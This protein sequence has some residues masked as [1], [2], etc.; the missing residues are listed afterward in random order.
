MTLYFAIK[1]KLFAS[2][3]GHYT[4]YGIMAM[5]VRLRGWKCIAFIPDVSA[6]MSKAVVLAMCCTVGQLDPAQLLD[7]VEDFL[8]D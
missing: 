3:I 4:S 7:V 1:Q 2:D 8:C 6:S 5:R